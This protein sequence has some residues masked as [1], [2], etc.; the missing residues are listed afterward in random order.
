MLPTEKLMLGPVVWVIWA[1]ELRLGSG[2]AEL[3]CLPAY[4]LFLSQLQKA[5]EPWVLK[6]SDLE[7]QD[8]SWKEVRAF[9]LPCY[10]KWDSWKCDRSPR[11][12][13]L[14][15][16]ELL[17]P[18]AMPHDLDTGRVLCW[19]SLAVPGRDSR[20]VQLYLSRKQAF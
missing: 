10:Q 3:F 15:N 12:H 4:A 1:I 7:K 13:T 19:S 16:T 5:A 9:Q 20:P 11:S 8:N 14:L 6:H 18:G 2:P 17:N